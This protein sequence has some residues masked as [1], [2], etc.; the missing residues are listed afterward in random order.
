MQTTRPKP[1]PTQAV[2]F[3]TERTVEEASEVS[4]TGVVMG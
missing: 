1:S 2:V 4:L 3:V